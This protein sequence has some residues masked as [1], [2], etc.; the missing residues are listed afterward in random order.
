MQEASVL[1][2]KPSHTVG[3][4]EL[5][6]GPSCIRMG[7]LT[8]AEGRQPLFSQN[9]SQHTRTHALRP[10]LCYIY[11]DLRMAIA[12]AGIPGGR[13]KSAQVVGWLDVG[14]E[15]ERDLFAVSATFTAR[16]LPAEKKLIFPS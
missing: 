11:R 6:W 13:I 16:V 1:L 15:G 8:S 5:H 14:P 4:G 2:I 12:A 10:A 3:E 7:P 9:K